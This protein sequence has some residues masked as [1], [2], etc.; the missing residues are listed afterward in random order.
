[1]SVEQVGFVVLGTTVALLAVGAL[2]SARAAHRVRAVPVS[3]RR[4]EPLADAYEIACLRGGTGRLFEVAAVRMSDTGR[5]RVRA[6]GDI[7]P[8]PG[9]LRPQDDVEAAFTDAAARLH[10]ESPRGYGLPERA[11]DDARVGRITERLV[12]EGLLNEPGRAGAARDASGY[13]ALAIGLSW[14]LTAAAAVLARFAG[15]YWI[16]L[17]YAP[18]LVA[19]CVLWRRDSRRH[20]GPT[21]LGRR[22]VRPAEQG[23]WAPDPHPGPDRGDA[24]RLGRVALGGRRAL[25]PRHV[26]APPPPPP[27]PQPEYVVDDPPGLGGL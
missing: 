15:S 22:A 12:R 20:P 21:P 25:P 2:H 18:L 16:L 5:L 13:L 26:L 3:P 11:P 19:P 6:R 23:T 7:V 27:P 24:E 14:P 4:P 1:M 9:A 8:D 10:T 17:W